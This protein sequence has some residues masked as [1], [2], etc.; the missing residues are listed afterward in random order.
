M[1]VGA[2]PASSPPGLVCANPVYAL[3]T[4]GTYA[5]TLAPG[6]WRVDGFYEINA[7]G[8]AFLG[9]ARIIDVAANQPIT[10]DFTVPYS[11]PATLAGEVKVTGGSPVIW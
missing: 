4:N 9:T 6:S 7:Y 5:L 3:A 10:A 2:C 11:K 8:G 1:G